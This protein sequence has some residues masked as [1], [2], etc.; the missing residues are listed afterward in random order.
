MVYL[1]LKRQGLETRGDQG[2]GQTVG[3]DTLNDR[4]LIPQDIAGVVG[5]AKA[6]F[7]NDPRSVLLQD[8]RIQE[9]HEPVALFSFLARHIHDDNLNELSDL[10][11]SQCHAGGCLQGIEHVLNDGRDIRVGG[12]DSCGFYFESW[13]RIQKDGS[14]WHDQRRTCSK[15]R[16]VKSTPSDGFR[17][18]RAC[19]KASG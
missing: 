5:H 16:N 10:W 13:V 7:S 8:A 18:S 19:P 3:R 12:G 17:R 6:A 4:A 14:G 11:S 15:G 1:M 9:H 2:D